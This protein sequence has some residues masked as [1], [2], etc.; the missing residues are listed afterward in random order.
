MKEH[1]IRGHISATR[2]HES[3]WSMDLTTF[4]APFI[5]TP[6]S[7]WSFLTLL[8]VESAELAI[9]KYD[10]TLII[11]RHW[12]SSLKFAINHNEAQS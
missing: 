12:G 7:I 1:T 11:R 9:I 10:V 6:A 2:K 5:S 8:D 4:L 3:L